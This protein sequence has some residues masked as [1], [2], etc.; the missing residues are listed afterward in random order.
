MSASKK[1]T[2]INDNQE[3]TS[4]PDLENWVLRLYVAGQ[5]PKALLAFKNLKIICEEQLNGRY[6]IEVIDLLLNPQLGRDDQILAIPTLVRKLPE[7]VKKIIG[8]LSNT[9]RVLIGLD[10]LPRFK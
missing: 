7:P 4:L 8:D 10:L 6:Q 5:S 2:K 1:N 3:I 9:E